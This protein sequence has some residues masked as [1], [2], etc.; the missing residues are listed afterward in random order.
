MQ[1]I[2]R[3]LDAPLSSPSTALYL[4]SALS[5][6]DHPS[7]SGRA[8][9]VDHQLSPTISA[10]I[11]R[12]RSTGTMARSLLHL[13]VVGVVLVVATLGSPTTSASLS[14]VRLQRRAGFTDADGSAVFR[15]CT[16]RYNTSRMNPLPQQ[17]YFNPNNGTNGSMLTVSRRFVHPTWLH[18]S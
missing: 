9:R 2:S 7:A 17:G 4:S 5:S 14:S 15:Q 3:P 1:D 10:W 18:S 11:D 13:L 6:A 16:Q 12:A 8:L